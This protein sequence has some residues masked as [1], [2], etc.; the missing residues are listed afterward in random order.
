MKLSF[1]RSLAAALITV[2]TSFAGSAIAQ[3]NAPSQRQ[4]DMAAARASR[5][6]VFG[7][8]MA[9]SDKEAAAFWPVFDQYEAAMDKVDDRHVK[10]VQSYA[11]VYK[12][13]TDADAR[14]KLDEVLAVQQA[15]LDV[16]KDY[17]AKFRAVIPDMKVTRFFQIDNKIHA[18]V[19]C[20]LAQMIPLVGTA[21]KDK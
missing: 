14:T 2:V 13:M 4:L 3:S 15:R 9:L 1:K 10:E 11:K 7:A 19:Q 8:N 6:A 21:G 12:T 5:K 20:D 16:Q 17:V 18:M